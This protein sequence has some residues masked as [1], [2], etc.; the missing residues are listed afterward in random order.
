VNH[1]IG[2][3]Y[4]PTA[5]G[6]FAG[7]PEGYNDNDS[8]LSKWESNSRVWTGALNTCYW[9]R[10]PGTS[11]R[12]LVVGFTAEKQTS[13]SAWLFR[14]TNPANTVL[15]EYSDDE[16]HQRMG[17]PT[18]YW[19]SGMTVEASTTG[20]TVDEATYGNLDSVCIGVTGTVTYYVHAV[21][22]TRMI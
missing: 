10:T 4:T 11:P 6:Y 1:F 3:D 22:I 17:D 2:V 20:T 19:A 15:P 14:R 7:P 13:P 12:K 5:F 21:A 16:F 18:L 9:G 8:W